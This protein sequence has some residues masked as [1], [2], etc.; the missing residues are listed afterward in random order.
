MQKITAVLG[1]SLL[2]ACASAQNPNLRPVKVAKALVEVGLHTAK[3]VAEVDQQLK[4]NDLKL[5]RAK[6]VI[7]EE[8][9]KNPVTA[10]KIQKGPQPNYTDFVAFPKRP[11]P[12]KAPGPEELSDLAGTYVEDAPPAAATAQGKPLWLQWLLAIIPIALSGLL[13]FGGRRRT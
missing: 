8:Y 7:E 12:L 4:V 6:T 10:K 11:D 3:G 2:T 1:I 9:R 5:K 13:M